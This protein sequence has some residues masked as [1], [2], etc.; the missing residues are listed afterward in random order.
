MIYYAFNPLPSLSSSLVL[1]HLFFLLLLILLQPLKV[2]DPDHPL[3]ALV[4]KARQERNGGVASTAGGV[5]TETMPE[6]QPAVAVEPQPPSAP[7][8]QYSADR[9]WTLRLVQIQSSNC[10]NLLTFDFCSLAQL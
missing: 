5:A 9:E 2:M 7:P 3:A 4:L 1:H 10:N 6:E 8:V